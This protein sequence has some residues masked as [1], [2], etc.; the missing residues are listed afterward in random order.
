M[1]NHDMMRVGSRVGKENINS[2]NA[3]NLLLD[4]TAV[5]YNG[6]EIGMMDLPRDFLKFDDCK[7]ESGIKY[8]VACSVLRLLASNI[9]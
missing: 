7:D 8:G 3:L 4:G 6:E 9:A 5:V 1:G 2:A